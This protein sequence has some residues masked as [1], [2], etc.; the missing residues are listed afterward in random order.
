MDR[1]REPILNVPAVVIVLLA[2]LCLVHAF[3]TLL[4]SDAAEQVFLWTFAFVPARY[5]LSPLTDGVL[6]GGAGADV[7]SFFTYALIHAD[8]THLA[9][10]AVRVCGHGAGADRGR[11]GVADRLPRRQGSTLAG[12]LRRRSALVLTPRP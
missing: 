11:S 7:W 4:L 10:A 3:R 12:E 9:R 8:L 5:D 2:V 1:T 6:P